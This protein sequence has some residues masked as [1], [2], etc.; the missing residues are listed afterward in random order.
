MWRLALDGTGYPSLKFHM[1]MAANG[2]QQQAD[3]RIAGL[4]L[5]WRLSMN[6]ISIGSQRRAQVL[7]STNVQQR[8]HV[9]DPPV[10][11]S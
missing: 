10:V 5:S 11:A 9:V 3:C 2:N 8:A 6:P 1:L 4:Q 7:G